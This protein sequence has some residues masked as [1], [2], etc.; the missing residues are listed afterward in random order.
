ML[1]AVL[2]ALCVSP[3]SQKLNAENAESAEMELHQKPTKE[4]IFFP[5]LPYFF[6]PLRRLP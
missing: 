2:C 6:D 3:K 4:G 1:L 5:A